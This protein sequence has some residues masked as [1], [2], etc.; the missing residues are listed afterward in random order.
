MSGGR[1][2]QGVF[3]NSLVRVVIELNIKH[4]RE[5]LKTER[6]AGNRETIKKLLAEEEQ[7]LVEYFKNKTG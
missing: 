7:K 6:D 2:L 5:L 4:Y 1:C 3:M